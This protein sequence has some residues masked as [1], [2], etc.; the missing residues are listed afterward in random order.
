MSP[1]MKKW[2]TK[3]SDCF[4]FDI[5]Y[6]ILRNRTHDGRQWGVGTFTTFDSNLRIIPVAYA[7]ICK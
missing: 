4:S 1:A 6:N 3:Y 7:I 2:V 5:T